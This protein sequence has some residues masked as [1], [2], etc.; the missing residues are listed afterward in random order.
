MIDPQQLWQTLKKF[1][2]PKVETYLLLTKP[3]SPVNQTG[4]AFLF[5]LT[6]SLIKKVQK[7]NY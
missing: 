4:E 2:Y 5:L 6:I 3:A 1:D 7:R